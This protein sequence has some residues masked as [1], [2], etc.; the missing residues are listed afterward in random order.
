[1]AS[2]R[3]KGARY[4]TA[5][6]DIVSSTFRYIG[7]GRALREAPWIVLGGRDNLSYIREI[8]TLSGRHGIL[9]T[10]QYVYTATIRNVHG[11]THV[12]EV[13]KIVYCK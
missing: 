3:A 7:K 9:W 11:I 13:W 4:S 1:M 12:Y 5:A 10:A 2:E 6:A 8:T